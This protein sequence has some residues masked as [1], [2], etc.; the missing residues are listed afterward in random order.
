[1]RI[2]TLTWAIQDS[3]CD[4]DLSMLLALTSQ[5]LIPVLAEMSVS[6]ASEALAGRPGSGI[7]NSVLLSQ[8]RIPAD[9][10]QK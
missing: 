9:Y 5:L 3:G 10:A 8:G 4:P 2:R 1:V 6:G 7:Q